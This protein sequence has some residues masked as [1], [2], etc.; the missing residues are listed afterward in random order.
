MEVRGKV[1]LVTGGA[2]GIGRAL[3][4]LFHREK[5]AGIGVA[6][7]DAAG[8]EAVA[9]EV[10]GVAVAT[11]VSQEEAIRRAVAVTE[12]RF[13]A[14]DLLCSNAGVA[15]SDGPGWMATSQ[16]NEQWERIWKINVM[17][18]VW[19]ARAVLPGM[20]ERG[21]GYLLHTVSAAGLLSQIGD[22]SYSTT[23]HAALGFAESLAITHGDQGIGVSVLCPQAVDTGLYHLPG[24]EALAEA[25]KVDGLLTPEEVAEVV[26]AGLAAE[27]FLILPH[28]TVATYMVRKAGDTDRWLKGMRR[29]RKSLFP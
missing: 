20:I 1:V 4:R 23:K 25:A 2:H 7:L 8:A 21:S 13:G 28:P 19:G 27:T 18:H 12:E 3:C 11:D 6:D 22:A 14:I 16:T 26:L 9:Q 29:F 10:G 5:A 15:Y 17:A 24:T